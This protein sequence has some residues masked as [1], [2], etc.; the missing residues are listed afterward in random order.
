[1]V[2]FFIKEDIAVKKHNAKKSQTTYKILSWGKQ[3]S[4]NRSK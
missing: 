4:K 3:S 1:M 2:C